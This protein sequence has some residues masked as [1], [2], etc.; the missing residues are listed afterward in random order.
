MIGVGK[1]LKLP[2]CVLNALQQRFFAHRRQI[3]PPFD[4]FDPIGSKERDHADTDRT[5]DSRHLGNFTRHRDVFQANDEDDHAADRSHDRQ[6][7]WFAMYRIHVEDDG[8][9]PHIIFAR[10][11]SP[12]I[13]IDEHQRRDD[14]HAAQ[15]VKDLMRDRIRPRPRRIISCGKIKEQERRDNEQPDD[16]IQPDDLRHQRHVDEYVQI[17]EDDAENQSICIELTIALVDFLD[18]AGRT[19][20]P[21]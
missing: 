2:I 1:L 10:R 17:I 19:V 12:R 7:K 8:D 3:I 11:R 20:I 5:H 18:E 4:I 13:G 21:K 14:Q 9:D 16:E 6:R 15:P